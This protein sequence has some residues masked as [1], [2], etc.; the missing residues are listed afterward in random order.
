[1][2]NISKLHWSLFENDS[3]VV[4]ETSKEAK[5]MKAAICTTSKL[6]FLLDGNVAKMKRH[7]GFNTLNLFVVIIGEIEKKGHG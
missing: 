2:T 6:F 5:G 3:I 7:N 4:C 1:M